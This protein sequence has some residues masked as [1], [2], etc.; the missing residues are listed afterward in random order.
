[1]QFDIDWAF[2][3]EQEG[4]AITEG[5][6]PS[7]GDGR[8]VG[9][10]GVTIG[11]GFDLGQHSEDDLNLIA[12]RGTP[13]FE[14]LRPYLGLRRDAAQKALSASPLTISSED[15][16]AIDQ[17][18]KREKASEVAARFDTAIARMGEAG[19]FFRELPPEAQTVIMSV[20]FQYGDLATRTPSFWSSILMQDWQAAHD[21]LRD[22]G[23][24]YPSR[25][26]RE[27]AYLEPLL[28][29]DFEEAAMSGEDTQ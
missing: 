23:D 11:T 5:Y 8:V 2:I 26:R 3:A 12:P 16:D 27:A 1:M 21:E 15:A 10:S 20:A 7:D 17:A 14:T 24:R 4:A 19:H 29:G 9:R 25:R 6:I 18:V 13:L 28:D 22:F